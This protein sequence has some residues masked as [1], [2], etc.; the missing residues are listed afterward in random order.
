ML[1]SYR[2]VQWLQKVKVLFPI[3]GF[4]FFVFVQS[5]KTANLTTL[6]GQKLL[7]S[8]NQNFP[9]LVTLYCILEN[10]LNCSYALT[11][12]QTLYIDVTEISK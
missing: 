6:D 1:L 12:L 11:F 8:D 7:F 5:V 2:V 4:Y 9:K 3:F 10:L